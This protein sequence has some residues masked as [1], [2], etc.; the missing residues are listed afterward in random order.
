MKM[1]FIIII[2]CFLNLGLFSND[3]LLALRPV[4]PYVMEDEEGN[5]SGIEYEIIVSAL[6]TKGYSVKV[7]LFP[8]ARMV[9]TIK[10]GIVDAAATILPSHETGKYLSDVYITYTNIA[11]GL[12]YSNFEINN[13]NDFKDYSIVAFQHATVVLGEDFRE[14]MKSN[15]NYSETSQ[16]ILQIKMLFNNRLDLA[17]GDFRILR[18]FIFDSNTA[19][20][21]TIPV[22]EYFTFPSTHYRVAFVNEQHMIDFNEGLSII[23]AN[24]TYDEII[25]KYSY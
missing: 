16:Q 9:D 17:V 22:K 5:I 3:I 21:S 1:I 4:P 20:D 7:Q 19:V 15:K 25:E 23:K 8:L 11:L 14:V 24:G 13:I 2:F 6:E 12:T 18:Y 10:F